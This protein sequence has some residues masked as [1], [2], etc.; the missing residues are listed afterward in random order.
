[1]QK[2]TIYLIL[3][4]TL[5]ILLLSSA[6]F[7]SYPYNKEQINNNSSLCVSDEDCVRVQTSC[8]PCSSSGQE[9]CVLK[10]E[11]ENYT[12]QLKNCS[13]RILCAAVYTCS[14]TTCSCIKG[15]CLEQAE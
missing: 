13:D 5:A 8:C 7:F 11:K 14:Q 4:I 12:N 3:T 6:I 2:R 15:K 10:L 1:M 9:T